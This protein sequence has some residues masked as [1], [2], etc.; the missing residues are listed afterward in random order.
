MSAYLMSDM[1]DGIAAFKRLLKYV[2]LE[3]DE[4]LILDDVRAKGSNEKC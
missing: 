2:D 1:H 3:K 4:I